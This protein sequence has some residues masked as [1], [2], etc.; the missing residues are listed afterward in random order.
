VTYRTILS[1][2]GQNGIDGIDIGMKP[3]GTVERFGIEGIAEE[4]EK[5]GAT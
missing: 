1:G 5:T 3:S 2:V 4:S